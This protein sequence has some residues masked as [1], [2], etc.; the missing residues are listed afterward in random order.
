MSGIRA[1][2][3]PDFVITGVVAPARVHGAMPFQ[4]NVT[5]CNEGRREAHSDVTLFISRDACFSED[6]ALLETV[7]TGPLAAGACVSV[8]V[9][10]Q[11]DLARTSTWF[12]GALVDKEARVR[13]LSEV[14]NVHDGVPVTF[15][16]PPDY[17]V[18]SLV[19]PSVVHPHG[20][21]TATAR[22]C[23]RGGGAGTAQVGLYRSNDS[24]VD[25]EDTRM[26]WL[27]G[28]PLEPGACDQV[29][30]GAQAGLSGRGYLAFIV[31]SADGRLE[32][33][34]TN[35][36][37]A[38]SAQVV[39]MVPD[40]VVAALKVPAV[41]PGD[42]NLPVRITVCN[43]GTA[44]AHATQ[45][46]FQLQ[47]LESANQGALNVTH[48][49]VPELAAN[50][51][52]EW[53]DAVG[54]SGNAPGRWRLTAT[55]NPAGAQLEAHADN[56]S[57]SQ[58]LRLGD[59]VEL[60]VTRVTPLTHALVPGAPF[61]T[62]VKVCNTG[63]IRA[64]RL[65]LHVSL[66]DG[67]DAGADTRVGTRV[68]GALEKGCVVLPVTG[69]V[70]AQAMSGRLYVKASTELIT[71]A[72]QELNLDDNVLVGPEVAIGR[73]LDLV[74]THVQALVP[75]VSA[76]A[77]MEVAVTVCNKGSIALPHVPIPVWVSFL[78]EPNTQG[79]PL[80]VGAQPTVEPLGSGEC[81][82]LIAEPISPPEAGAWRPTAWVDESNTFPEVV[83]SNNL[84][85]GEVFHVASITGLHITALQAPTVVR[86]NTSFNATA[87]V[88]NRSALPQNGPQ[89]RFFLRTED[90]FP[91]AEFPRRSQPGRLMS[92]A[93]ASVRLDGSS[94]IP[95][96]TSPWQDGSYR[97]VAELEAPWT[98][99]SLGEQKVLSFSA[100][101]GVGRGG[102]FAVTSVRATDS[103]P[104]GGLFLPTVRVCNQG[105]TSGGATLTTYL[106]RD[107]H[108]EMPGDIKLREVNMSLG[109]GSCRDVLVEAYANVDAG[110]VWY[111]G[112][113]VRA[114][115]LST[116]DHVKSNDT[117]VGGRIIVTP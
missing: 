37:S 22:V 116:P 108:I 27:F 95:Y 47:S 57:R 89:I 84:A 49:N 105:L 91:V 3:L 112:A 44:R 60:G 59:W 25:T 23:N 5:V 97:L 69:T 9:A 92:G 102:D 109:P 41:E 58:V 31:A 76:R 1:G 94:E 99:G 65:A 56:N 86:A 53:S 90:G 67:L 110:D 18:E 19:V 32:E 87:T 100:P 63:S 8:P 107:E 55:V 29:S 50:Q 111:V 28:V 10:V 114:L 33:D 43:Q 16:S 74:V 15:D 117:R 106:S 66:S 51:C 72:G 14:N 20:F 96:D 17:V 24:H 36:A 82:T 88:C 93:C 80:L 64:E 68:F 48:R 75:V 6:D 77:T 54:S 104:R 73:G 2:D 70:P 83:E 40:Y 13:E 98:F 7:P 34:V 101:L 62:E 79:L 85:R 46:H 45:V 81:S 4:V 26:G 103:V 12:V 42:G 113:Q 35:N 52:T 115:P 61:T 11:G 21:F 78:P 39:G 71:P 30:L 38:V